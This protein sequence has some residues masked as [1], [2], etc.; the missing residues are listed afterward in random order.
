MNPQDCKT[1]S[2]FYV[3]DFELEIPTT[4]KVLEAVVESGQTYRPDETSRSGLDLA[5]HI[6]L[7]DA[8]LLDAVIQ[9]EVAPIP[10][11]SDACGL[12]NGRDCA[13]RYRETIPALLEK[14]RGLSPEH[15]AKDID[16]FGMMR[17]PA[18]AFLSMALRHS[19]HHRGQLSSYLR[20]MGGK[21]PGIYGPSADEPMQG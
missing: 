1:A 3:G 11:Q 18:I 15:L 6:A 17:M 10:D 19:A 9:G 20:A 7:E 12:M 8:W 13:A 5:R 21:V 16:F 4:V 2:A 14:V